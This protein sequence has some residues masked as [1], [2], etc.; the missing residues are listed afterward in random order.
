MLNINIKELFQEFYL[1]S[2]TVVL[3]NVVLH[4]S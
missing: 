2:K 3:E 1:L 4:Y